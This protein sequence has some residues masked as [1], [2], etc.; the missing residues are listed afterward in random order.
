MV[1]MAVVGVLAAVALPSL[2]EHLARRA[3]EGVALELLGDLQY[4]RSESA[5]RNEAVAVTKAAGCH[6]IHAAN[7]SATCTRGGADVSPASALLK[8][9]IQDSMP[10][11]DVQPQGGLT[12]MVFEPV[13]TTASFAGTAPGSESASWQVSNASGTL[14]VRVQ[15][16][17]GGRASA[18][19]SAGGPLPGTPNCPP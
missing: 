15:V 16:N 2:M 12:G 10:A 13:G 6:V 9:V 7:A 19:V 11:A 1:V 3:V 5:Q 14:L 4:A 17:L 8:S 18:C